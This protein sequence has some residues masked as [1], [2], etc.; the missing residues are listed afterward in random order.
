MIDLTNKRFGRL[1]VIR[2]ADNNKFRHIC[3]LCL[4]DCGKEKVIRGCNLKSGDTKSCG[5]LQIDISTK[6]G[7][8][9]RGKESG[10]YHSWEG[11][12]QRCT[13]PNNSA[14]HRYG[15]RGITVCD[16]WRKFENF[17]EDMGE[18]PTDKTIDRI[19]NDK[20][21]FKENCRWATREEQNRNKRSNRLIIHDG[22]TQC[23]IAWAE[24]IG[25]NKNTIL[26]RLRRGWSIDEALTTPVGKNR[27]SWKH[28]N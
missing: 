27:K 8:A 21:Y 4:C 14:Y 1:I 28:I 15:G 25:V 23:L 10:I 16:R 9:V 18:K 24:E 17:L 6:H 7:Y 12:I 11:I 2:I 20:G 26:N 13:N 3:W 22:R 19:K 5:C